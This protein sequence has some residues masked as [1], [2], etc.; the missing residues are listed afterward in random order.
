MNLPSTWNELEVAVWASGTVKKFL[1]HILTEHAIH[2]W[3]QMGLE[4]NF[5]KAQQTLESKARSVICKAGVCTGS[6]LQYKEN[7]Q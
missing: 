7:G 4:E 6:Q 1:M 2:E 3:K 5:V